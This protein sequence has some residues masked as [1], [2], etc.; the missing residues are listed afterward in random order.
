MAHW[1]TMNQHSKQQTQ[2]KVQKENL[3][4]RSFKKKTPPKEGP[5]KFARALSPGT[6]EKFQERR[7][8]K[9]DGTP[10]PQEGG[11]RDPEKGEP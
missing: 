3:Q 11:A 9:T 2:N 10:T 1:K 7:R 5:E 6:L 8:S 4:Q